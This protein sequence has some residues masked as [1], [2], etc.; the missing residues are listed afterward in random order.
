MSYNNIKEAYAFGFAKTLDKGNRKKTFNYLLKEFKFNNMVNEYNGLKYAHFIPVRPQS[1]CAFIEK[2]PDGSL[3]VAWFTGDCEGVCSTAIAYSRLDKDSS[4][5]TY[6]KIVSDVPFQANQNP[7][8][9]YDDKIDKLKIYHTSQIA[10]DTPS[11]I[12]KETGFYGQES[13]V[14]HEL[15]SKD[16]HGNEWNDSKIIVNEMGTFTKGRVTEINTNRYMLPVYMT[17][18]DKLTNYGVIHWYDRHEKKWSKTTITDSRGLAQP[19]IVKYYD[20]QNNMKLR[21][22]F[23]NRNNRIGKMCYMDSDDV[24]KTWKKRVVTPLVNGNCSIDTCLLNNGYLLIIYTNSDESRIRSPLSI[25]ISAD[26]GET[27]MTVKDVMPYYKAPEHVYQYAEFSYPSIIQTSDNQ[28]H[29]VYTYNR[30]TI[31]YLSFDL[32]WLMTVAPKSKGANR[33]WTV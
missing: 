31:G 17:Q 2:L 19:S 13:S 23:R 25:A 5:W 10:K 33:F 26:M 15:V 21:A 29:V 3:G 11:Y 18:G 32:N 6:G 1:H 20:K 12:K 14:V 27:F 30:M 9:F 28:I 24:G 22:F 7:V 16:N 8:L 4:E